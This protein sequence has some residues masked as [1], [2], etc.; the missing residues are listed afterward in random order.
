MFYMGNIHHKKHELEH[1]KPSVCFKHFCAKVTFWSFCFDWTLHLRCRGWHGD[2]LGP[3]PT[4]GGHTEQHRASTKL[5]AQGKSRYVC[6]A[7]RLEPENDGSKTNLFFLRLI[8]SFHVKL[9]GA[10]VYYHLSFFLFWYMIYICGHKLNTLRRGDNRYEK[11]QV[12][13]FWATPLECTQK[14]ARYAFFWDIRED[15]NGT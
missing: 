5:P 4:H 2:R 14:T 1:S 12:S 13:F 9:Q 15:Y 11:V 10:Y 7:K 8:F 3:Y 6:K